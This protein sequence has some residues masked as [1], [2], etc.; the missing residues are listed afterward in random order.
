MRA[1]FSI[2]TLLLATSV[3]SLPAQSVAITGGKIYP[4]SG[5]VIESA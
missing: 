2:A 1:Q 5:P 3:A 4:V